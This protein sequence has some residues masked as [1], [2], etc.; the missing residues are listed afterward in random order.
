[1]TE[2]V[3]VRLFVLLHPAVLGALLSGCPLAHEGPKP[4]L[5]YEDS[6]CFLYAGEYCHPA[7]R[8]RGEAGECRPKVDLS[9]LDMKVGPQDIPPGEADVWSDAHGDGVADTKAEENGTD[10][11]PDSIADAQ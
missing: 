9:V 10:S 11:Q 3:V 5:C 4:L 1:M 8:A 2:N 7:N 6:D